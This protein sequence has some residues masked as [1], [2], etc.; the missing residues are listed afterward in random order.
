MH[1]STCKGDPRSRPYI[2]GDYEDR[3]YILTHICLFGET[4]LLLTADHRKGLFAED[5]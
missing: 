4:L 5:L 1:T 3:P 2:L